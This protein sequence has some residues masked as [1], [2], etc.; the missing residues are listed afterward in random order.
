MASSSASLARC[1]FSLATFLVVAKGFRVEFSNDFKTY[2]VVSSGKEGGV[3]FTS[4]TGV[5][6][7]L[8]G[9]WHAHLDGSL[10]LT[11]TAAV[12]G[13]DAG[14]GQYDGTQLVWRA[15][16]TSMVT[17]AKSYADGSTVVFE[18]EFP[19]GANG[20]SL[21]KLANKTNAE[22]I[23]N[24][25]CFSE[26]ALANTLSWR[27]SFVGAVQN[28]LSNG[29]L[30]GPTVF[31]NASDTSMET[32]VV[33]SAL[34]NFK[35]TSAGPGTAWDGRTVA[36][37]PGTSGTISSLPPGHKQLFVLRRN[38]AREGITATIGSWGQTLQAV[39][40]TYRVPDVTLAKVGYQTDN[41]A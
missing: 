7:F 32:I 28:G 41:G 13:T 1:A 8:D 6:V 22:V 19:E 17:T 18:Y 16:N 26:Y 4:T 33:G 11:R 5:A 3:L 23:V 9:R 27:G 10:K 29:P 38:R 2:S 20:T 37:A 34:N 21:V 14:I 35:S 15:G 39:H 36:W 31:Y 25:P 12:H 24:F 40:K 30:G